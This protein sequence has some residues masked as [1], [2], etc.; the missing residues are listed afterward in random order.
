LIVNEQNNYVPLYPEDVKNISSMKKI[1][2]NNITRHLLIVASAIF[3]LSPSFAQG[4]QQHTVCRLSARAKTSSP[5]CYGTATGAITVRASGSKG[6]VSYS[7]NGGIPQSSGIFRGL[8]VG[9]YNIT[10]SGEGCTTSIRTMIVEPEQLTATASTTPASCFGYSNGELTI[11]PS[12]GTP[13][14]TFTLGSIVQSS[15]SFSGLGAG[16]YVIGVKDAKGCSTT[17]VASI[18]HTNVAPIADP[19]PS[20]GLK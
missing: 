8:P 1:L 15:N 4:S 13:G 14:Y 17:M 7:L 10:V 3:L 2:S 12:G 20:Y 18:P 6:P 16:Q 19:T 9:Y 11:I 5:L